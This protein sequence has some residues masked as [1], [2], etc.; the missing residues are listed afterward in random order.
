MF[1]SLLIRCFKYTSQKTPFRHQRCQSQ[2]IPEQW[3]SC[4]HIVR[5]LCAAFWQP[6]APSSS[7]W[8][9]EP[10]KSSS[11][12]PTQEWSTQKVSVVHTAV[13]RAAFKRQHS[14]LSPVAAYFEVVVG[15]GSGLHRNCTFF[16]P[17]RVVRFLSG[18]TLLYPRSLL[19]ARVRVRRRCRISIV[20]LTLPG[21]ACLPLKLRLLQVGVLPDLDART[22]FATIQHQVHLPVHLRR[23]APLWARTGLDVAPAVQQQ[24]E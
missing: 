23:A 8:A 24:I 9:R 16:M 21:D 11:P 22:R 3:L 5:V 7:F 17:P 4:V 10:P 20:R 14:R 12:S 15:C 2:W 18:S 6:P 13:A 1:M 19:W